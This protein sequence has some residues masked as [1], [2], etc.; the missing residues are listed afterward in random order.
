MNL[1]RQR[2]LNLFFVSVFFMLLAG[3]GMTFLY[4]IRY[5]HLPFQDSLARWGH[6]A[7]VIGNELKKASGADTLKISLPTADGGG[8]AAPVT[9]ESGVRRCQIDGKTVFSD[10][11]C[12]AQNPTSRAV[13]LHDTQGFVHPVVVSDTQADSSDTD[14]SKKILDQAISRA[15]QKTTK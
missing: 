14:M 2:G 6:S 7:G 13:K 1:Q 5:G 9:L 8:M 11:A 4:T 10:T 15:E 3:G 12:S